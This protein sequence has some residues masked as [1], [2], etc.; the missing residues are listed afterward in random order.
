MTSHLPR[1]SKPKSLCPPL[2]SGDRLTRPEFERRYA[3]ALHIKKAE[4]IIA[5][6]GYWSMSF[7]NRLKTNWSGFV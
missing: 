6:T 5:A 3:A 7:G 4:L 2:E 1:H